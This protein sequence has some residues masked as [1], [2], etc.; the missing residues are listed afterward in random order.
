M[1]MKL[2]DEHNQKV[3][4]QLKKALNHNIP[5]SVAK[6][7]KDINNHYDRYLDVMDLDL[8]TNQ[9]IHNIFK[10]D[11]DAYRLEIGISSSSESEDLDCPG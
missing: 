2:R 11:V 6:A 4:K 10:S 3:Q 8:A 1:W 9:Q 5:E 7:I